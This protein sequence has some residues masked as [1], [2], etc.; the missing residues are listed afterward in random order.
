MVNA[1]IP[2]SQSPADGQTDSF[3]PENVDDWP[4]RASATVVQYVGTVRDKTT[5]PAMVASRSVVYYAAMGLIGVVAAILLLL[6]SVRI[7]VSVTA[8]APF[9]EAGESWL[10]FL[11]LGFVFLLAGMIMWRMKE[12]R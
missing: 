11:I 12:A 4:A 9:V 10:A 3:V 7:L 8:Y 2:A 5:G 6:L 1:D